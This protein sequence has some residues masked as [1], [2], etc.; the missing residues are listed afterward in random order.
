VGIEKDSVVNLPKILVPNSKTDVS[1]S[2]KP[3]TE[4]RLSANVGGY[5]STFTVPLPPK[6]QAPV[7]EQ[8]PA[9]VIVR[10]YLTQGSERVSQSVSCTNGYSIV[11]GSGIC[12]STSP[13]NSGPLVYSGIQ[14]RTVW[15]C[16]WA[17]YSPEGVGLTS[18]AI[19]KRD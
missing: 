5:A 3:D 19:C 2:L 4:V 15:T 13:G 18:Q 16:Q 7:V 17:N 11:P 1:L 12:N 9:E 8:G 10:K 6:I 14:G